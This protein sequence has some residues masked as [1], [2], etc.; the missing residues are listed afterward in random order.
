MVKVEDLERI[1]VFKKFPPHLLERVA[2]EAQ[3]SIYGTGTRLFSV[4]EPVDTFY[5]IIMGQVSLTVALNPDVDVILDNLQSGASFGNSAF[6]AKG[7]AAYSAECQEPC[8]VIT[9]GGEGMRALF[10]EDHELGYRFMN[11]VALQLKQEMD[12]RAQMI[13]NTLGQ[14]PEL[15]DRINDIEALIPVY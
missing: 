10:K 7:T 12:N 9:L 2:A 14:Y 5:M 6:F 11:G 1:A 15:K 4:G 13:M 8:E 3:L